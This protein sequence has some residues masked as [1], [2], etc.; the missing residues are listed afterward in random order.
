MD[1]NSIIHII[2][3][4]FFITLPLYPAKYMFILRWIPLLLIINWFVFEGCPLTMIDKNLNDEGFIEALTKPFITI[5]KKRLDILTNI[6]LF[7]IFALCERKYY[8]YIYKIKK[9]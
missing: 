1:L 4:L 5:S 6:F 7:V 3:I 2:F 8:R 9:K